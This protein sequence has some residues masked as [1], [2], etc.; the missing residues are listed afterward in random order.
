MKHIHSNHKH[1]L[2]HCTDCDVVSCKR[3]DKFWVVEDKGGGNPKPSSPKMLQ[4]EFTTPFMPISNMLFV[5]PV[6]ESMNRIF[7]NR[8]H[9]D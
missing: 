8:K 5:D 6:E 1:K 7:P 3:C 2:I 9:H 4:F